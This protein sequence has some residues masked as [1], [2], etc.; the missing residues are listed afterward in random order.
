[1]KQKHYGKTHYI[2]EEREEGDKLSMR[3]SEKKKE[4][5][6]LRND[7]TLFLFANRQIRKKCSEC[8]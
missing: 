6:K 5:E 3:K 8:P 2:I 4:E 7:N 1:M